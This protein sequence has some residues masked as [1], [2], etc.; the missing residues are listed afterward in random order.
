MIRIGVTGGIGSGKS[1]VC[2]LFAMLGA[3]LYDSDAAAR[4][5]M[6]NSAELKS[7][8]IALLG[9]QSYCSETLDRRYV[10]SKVFTNS[11]LL[12]SLNAIVHPAVARDF[13]QWAS[14]REAEGAAY[15]VMESAILFESGFDALVDKSIVVSAPEE[16]RIERTI[17][18]DGSTPEAVRRRIAA[19]WSDEQ[20]RQKADY[21]IVNDE[22]QA[23][24]PQV[25][26]LN[27]LFKDESRSCGN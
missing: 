8:I 2:R 21:Q 25:I 17:L 9:S 18:R 16:V 14:Q 22:R 11:D 4:E 5:L 10:A 27:K 23:V 24:W 19:Q 15:I 7:S 13:E 6:N 3:P 12:S 20:R 1:T 26:A